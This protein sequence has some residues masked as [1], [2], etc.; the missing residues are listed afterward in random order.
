MCDRDSLLVERLEVL[1]SA[2]ERIPRRF[3]GIKMA[4]DFLNSD[5]GLDKLD[6]ICMILIATG[7]AFKQIDKKTSGQLLSRYPQIDWKGIKGI[8]NVIAHGY[9]DVDAEQVF[10]VCHTDIPILIETV[11]KIIDD[12][13]NHTFR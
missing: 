5:D 10:A 12:L 3:A 2:L 8:R 7:E 4:D 9:F 13:N 11:R 1:L 6:A